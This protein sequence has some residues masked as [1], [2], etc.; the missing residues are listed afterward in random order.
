[1]KDRQPLKLRTDLE[2]QLMEYRG[3][4]AVLVSDRLGL[5]KNPVLLQ[6]EALEVLA[7]IDGH[8]EARDI[9]LE[10]LRN[11]GYSLS[12]AG[13]VGEILDSFRQLWIL[14]TPEFQGRKQELIREFSALLVREPVLAGH[15]YPEEPVE[16]KEF[17]SQILKLETLPP[18][19]E[20]VVS[21]ARPMVLIAPHID[22]QR[23][24]RLYSL[25]YRCLAG[26]K[27]RR[28]IILGTG[29]AVANRVISLTEKDFSTP[30]GLVKTDKE[31]VGKLRQ[32]S[33]DLVSADDFAH[34][35]EHSLEFQL[36]FLQQVLE[37]EFQLVPVLFGSFHPWLETAERASEIPGLKAFLDLLAEAAAGPESLVV[38]GVDLCHI[39]QKFGH[40]QPA[41]GL[42]EA[43]LEYDRQLIEILLGWQPV[44]FWKLFQ[45]GGDRFNVCGFSTL[46]VLLESVKVN[47]G[48]FLGYEM[49]DEPATGSA[50]SFAS[51]VY[52]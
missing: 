3:Q 38:A 23:G 22:L 50:V 41:S 27:Y 45:W 24:R 16:L 6:G 51:L 18:E 20:N 32:T 26:K 37:S 19:V 11:R 42:R 1:M 49:A 21:T 52:F 4:R 17:L 34:K 36:I 15:A 2:L 8:R 46:A 5:I 10:F 14:D 13:L 25:A 40:S 39:G 7:L 43:A 35:N 33:P 31:L 48:L 28:V 29:H 12:G 30:L 47:K 44:D 9:Q